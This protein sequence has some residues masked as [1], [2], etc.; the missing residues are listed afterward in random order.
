MAQPDSEIKQDGHF[1]FSS[2]DLLLEQTCPKSSAV[3]SIDIRQSGYQQ[4]T[5]LFVHTSPGP[6]KN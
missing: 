4:R 1:V 2:C 6:K 3:S 5:A